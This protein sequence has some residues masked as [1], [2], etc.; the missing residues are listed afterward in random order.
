[1]AGQSLLAAFHQHQGLNFCEF[2]RPGSGFPRGFPRFPP[3]PFSPHGS[4]ARLSLATRLLGC[5][6]G[7]TQ[8]RPQP[9]LVSAEQSPLAAVLLRQVPQL[10]RVSGPVCELLRTLFS[11]R[12]PG[13]VEPRHAVNSGVA[14]GGSGLS[15]TPARFGRA[16]PPGRRPPAP[17]TPTLSSF[18]AGLRIASHPF[19]LTVPGLG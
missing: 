1:M 16:E 6:P 2:A 10:Y 14:P 8:V 12:F 15:T 13:S 3:S 19:L 9:L 11:S 4:W 7:W 17:G 18:R 5:S